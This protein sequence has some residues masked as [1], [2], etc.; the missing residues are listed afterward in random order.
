MLAPILE[1]MRTVIQ[2]LILSLGYVGIAIVMFAENVFPPIPSEL[3]MPFAGWLARDGRLDLVSCLVAGT[4]GTVAGAVVLYYV[5]TLVDEPVVRRFVRAYG[6]Y[7]LLSDADVDRTFAY[8]QRHGRAVVFFGRMVPIVRSLISVPAGMNRMPMAPFLAY[9]TAG[10]LI[11]T[12]LL[13]IAGWILG[14][15][16]DQ[17]IWWVNQYERI[18]LVVGGVVGTWWLA[19]LFLPRIRAARAAAR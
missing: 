5:G 2:D 12:T 6:R 13:T 1:L 17:I 9:T 7:W 15:S 8:F 3:V 14:E 18:F 10:S 16:W 11:W 19:R 4:V